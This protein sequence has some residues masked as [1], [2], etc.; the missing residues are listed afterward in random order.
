[1]VKAT[2]AVRI[3]RADA[4]TDRAGREQVTACS[5]SKAGDSDGVITAT[6]SL[7]VPDLTG[8]AG[9]RPFGGINRPRPRGARYQGR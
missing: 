1:M 4:A 6:S 3:V 5:F 7:F 9:G 8:M 2:A